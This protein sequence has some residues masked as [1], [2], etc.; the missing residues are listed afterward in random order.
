M[1]AFGQMSVKA[2]A[3]YLANKFV[4]SA[5][6]TTARDPEVL[7]PGDTFIDV[8]GNVGYDALLGSKAVG[9]T[10][11]VVT[12]EASA[13]I[14]AQ[15]Q[16]NLQRNGADNVRAVKVA[17]ASEPGEITLYGGDQGNQGRTSA[18]SREG[19]TAIETVPSLPLDM[20]LTEEE[21][22]AARLIKI[23][24]EGG[25]LAVLERLAETLDSYGPDLRILVEMSQED[26]GRSETVFDQLIALGFSAYAIPND[27]KL[28]SYL[29][30]VAAT[31][32]HE[33]LTCLPEVQ[34]DIYFV[35]EP[36]TALQ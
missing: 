28:V 25:E 11:R 7:R 19:L 36:G 2:W 20:I 9:A 4:L 18:F 5:I 30:P 33:R 16:A 22:H 26:A 31:Q 21:R 34:T 32:L 35:R 24:I 14:F 29:K 27:Y 1:S 10:G 15:L 8:G 6:R 23:D 17:V 12:I 13:D 3:L